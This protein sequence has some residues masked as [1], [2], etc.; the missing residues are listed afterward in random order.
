MWYPGGW[1]VPGCGKGVL[2]LP[3]AAG[4]WRW[5]SAPMAWQMSASALVAFAFH[6]GLLA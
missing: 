6:G 1:Q 2:L 4:R 5:D 3:A